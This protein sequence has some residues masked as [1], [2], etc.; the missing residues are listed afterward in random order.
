MARAPTVIPVSDYVF[1]DTTTAAKRLFW[2]L[3]GPLEGAIQVAPSQYYEPD[4]V[5]EPYIGPDGT[6]HAEVAHA[7]LLEPPVSSL[8]VKI[9]TIDE[10]EQAWLALHA[11][12]REVPDLSQRRMGPRPGDDSL[13]P[14][15]Y[16]GEVLTVHEFVSAVHPWLMAR[17]DAILVTVL[18]S[19]R[20]TTLLQ[21]DRGVGVV[22]N[23]PETDLENKLAVVRFG[24]GYVNVGN[25]DRWVWW[26][27]KPPAASSAPREKLSHEERTRRTMERMM[28]R[29]AAMIRAREKKEAAQAAEK[30]K[31]T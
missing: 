27:R 9:L 7:P 25:E 18:Q 29:A 12:C 14:D 1:R 11:R 3:N 8:T 26:Y 10:W 17:R 28:A 24:Q 22:R 2:R 16:V 23:P 21:R 20:G 6:P 5:M 4:A 15:L 31:E 19:E 30:D 13:D